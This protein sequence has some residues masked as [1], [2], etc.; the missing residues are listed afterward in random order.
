MI[1]GDDPA[2]PSPRAHIDSHAN[3]IVWFEA[4]ESVIAD[5]DTPAEAHAP[6]G[7]PPPDH[8]EA[9]RYDS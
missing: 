8:Q 2:A 9:R 4:G 1:L 5:I 6:P 3:E 7:Q